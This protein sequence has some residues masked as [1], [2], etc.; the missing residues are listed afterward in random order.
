[1]ETTFDIC[2]VCP[3]C[4]GAGGII[5]LQERIHYKPCLSCKGTGRALKPSP[6]SSTDPRVVILDIKPEDFI[7]K[8]KTM[9]IQP[10]KEHNLGI[11][12]FL[13][14][15]QSQLAPGIELTFTY[16]EETWFFTVSYSNQN[17]VKFQS[18][19]QFHKSYLIYP[20]SEEIAYAL[21][22]KIMEHIKHFNE[23]VE[24]KP[25]PDSG[26]GVHPNRVVWK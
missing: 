23:L 21:W 12:S 18:S 3:D 5:A 10:T 26:N 20:T 24:L 17:K 15:L 11:M 19:M 8:P 7:Y 1:M 22:N 14:K 6:F 2:I 25:N 4:L 9:D 16:R 13:E